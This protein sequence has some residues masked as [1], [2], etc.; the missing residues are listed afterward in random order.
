MKNNSIF[1]PSGLKS[2]SVLCKEELNNNFVTIIF[3]RNIFPKKNIR[4]SAQRCS[5][6]GASFWIKLVFYGS[7]LKKKDFGVCSNEMKFIA[8]QNE[9]KNLIFK[10]GGIFWSSAIDKYVWPQ[11]HALDKMSKSSL[12]FITYFYPTQVSR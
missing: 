5:V 10:I 1:I 12:F 4:E 6:F 7:L 2:V 11:S 3:K 9:K 8:L